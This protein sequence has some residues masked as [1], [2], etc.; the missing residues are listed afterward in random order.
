MAPPKLPPTQLRKQTPKQPPTQLSKQPTK[1]T[2]KQPPTQP[3]EQLAKE[4]AK[5]PVKPWRNSHAKRQLEQDLLSGVVSLD[6]T[7]KGQAVREMR[8]CYKEFPLHQ[9]SAR[10]R[11]AR[12]TIN[13]K[14]GSTKAGITGLSTDRV[15]FPPMTHDVDGRRRWEG[16]AAK[17]LLKEDMKEGMHKIMRPKELW[18]SR[19]EYAEFELKVFCNHIYQ[20][21]KTKIFCDFKASKKAKQKEGPEE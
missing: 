10:L 6:K 20:S 16:S 13:T 4:P 9:F 18:E 17:K 2:P 1:Q 21:H 8:P 14:K 5:T 11:D 3:V 19:S 15:A 7:M 12:K